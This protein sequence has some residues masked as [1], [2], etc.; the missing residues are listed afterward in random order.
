M[1]PLHITAMNAAWQRLPSN[2]PYIA[3][4]ISDGGLAV[5][6]KKS[7]TLY[8]FEEHAA[9]LFLRLEQGEDA[10]DILSDFTGET[11]QDVAL[12]LEQC[13]LLLSGQQTE[14]H[15]AYAP[16]LDY[17]TSIPTYPNSGK[18]YQLLNTNFLIHADSP[19]YQELLQSHLAHLEVSEHPSKPDIVFALHQ[20][21]DCI[22]P[23]MNGKQIHAGLTSQRLYPFM[24]D[25]M[26]VTAY[27]RVPYLLTLH[28]AALYKDDKCILLPGVS[29]AGK[30]TLTAALLSKGYQLLTDETAVIDLFDFG[31]YPVPMPLG[32]KEGS[33]QLLEHLYPTLMSL[34][35]HRRFDQ[36]PVRYLPPPEIQDVTLARISATHIIFPQ[37]SDGE[38]GDLL[39]ISLL[40]ALAKL[41]ETGYQVQDKLGEEKAESMLFWLAGLQAYEVHYQHFN[42]AVEVIE[43]L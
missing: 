31:I 1:L 22:I 7:D 5:Y 36:K 10:A 37:V 15:M 23:L 17:P 9:S 28:A 35:A 16:A 43:T 38:T 39:S 2:N 6:A 3:L 12:L 21:G 8:G 25:W 42:Q 13:Q 34:P 20:Q 33:W 29:G 11:Q 40:Q 41:D 24:Q 14:K 4:F 26:R 30:S 27:Q 19:A 18:I 32:L